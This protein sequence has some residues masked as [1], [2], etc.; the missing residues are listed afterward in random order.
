MDVIKMRN[1]VEILKSYYELGMS[2]EEIAQQQHLSKSKVNR[3]IKKAISDGYIKI[4]VNYPITPVKEL[5]SEFIREFGLKKAFFAPVIVDDPELIKK[6]VCRALANDLPNFVRND[7]IIGVSWGNTIKMLASYLPKIEGKG[8]KIVQLNGGIARNTKP[9]NGL[10]II[11][12]FSNAFQGL[13]YV[14]PMPAIVDNSLIVDVLKNDSQIHHV[15]DLM[16]KSRIAIFG[17]GY[18]SRDSVLYSA[19]YFK[20]EEYDELQKKGAVG[21]I[22]S[23]YYDIDGKIIDKV[24]DSRT[25]GISWETLKQKEYSIGIVS[26]DEKVKSL[27]GALNGGYINTLYSDENTARKVLNLYYE[28]LEKNKQE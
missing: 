3:I 13:G 18:V 26:G 23:R 14:L 27:L 15:F 9:T 6:D 16:E 12:E 21:D 1:V 11:E 22:C 8:I 24:L 20:D 25:V 2:Q 19:K 10:Q 7:D 5:E 4:T 17:I 28:Q